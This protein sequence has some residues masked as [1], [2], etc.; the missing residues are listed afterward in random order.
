MVIGA[1]GARSAGGVITALPMLIA[2]E[3]DV[4]WT[5][6]RAEQ[7]NYGYENRAGRAA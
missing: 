6:V 1:R 2:E 7:L 3:L 4:D 5:R